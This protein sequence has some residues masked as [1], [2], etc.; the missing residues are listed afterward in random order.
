MFSFASSPTATDD[1]SS[2]GICGSGATF[3]IRFPPVPYFCKITF[4]KVV[5]V[6]IADVYSS[7]VT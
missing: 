5:D 4:M 2:T 1:P 6:V 7:P 3:Q